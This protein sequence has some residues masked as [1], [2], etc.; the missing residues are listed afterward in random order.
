MLCISLSLDPG[1]IN[2]PGERKGE[3]EG[4][5]CKG[6]G[7]GRGMQGRFEGDQK[8]KS[9]HPFPCL[10]TALCPVFI[11]QSKHKTFRLDQFLNCSRVSK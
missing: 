10:P 11:D 4:R 2:N 3:S 9:K 1:G 6:R 5:G 8:Q 7:G